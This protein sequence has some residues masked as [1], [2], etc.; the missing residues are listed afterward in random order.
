MVISEATHSHNVDEEKN[1]KDVDLMLDN[2][3]RKRL[4]GYCQIPDRILLVKL[5]WKPIR[6]AINVLYALTAQNTKEKIDN[7]HNSQDSAKALCKSQEISKTPEKKEKT[8][9]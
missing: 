6:I 1:E 9:Y 4:L 2:G 7:F 3:M 5:K 8:K